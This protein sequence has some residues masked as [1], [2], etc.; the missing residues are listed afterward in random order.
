MPQDWQSVINT[1][2]D[3]VPRVDFWSLRLVFDETEMLR[4]RDGVVQP[5]GL[6]QSRGVHVTL[7]DRGGCAYAATS[8]LTRKGLQAACE[9]AQRWLEPSRRHALVE[10]RQ[11]P[12]PQR[13]GAYASPVGVPWE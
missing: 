4:V 13:S 2:K 5:P 8:A 12:R 10:A 3:V 9:H 6:A 7:M 1:F 11:L